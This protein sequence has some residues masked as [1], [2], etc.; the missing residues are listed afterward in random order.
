[1]LPKSVQEEPKTSSQL[2]PTK[3]RPIASSGS[4]ASQ[5]AP[6]I[7]NT[8]QQT[9]RIGGLGLGG[10]GGLGGGLILQSSSSSS[11]DAIA[12]YV[13]GGEGNEGVGV[14]LDDG[15]N[16]RVRPL[17]DYVWDEQ[18]GKPSSSFLA[19][20]E[21][22]K[23]RAAQ[24]T[25]ARKQKQ[26]KDHEET[27]QTQSS[28][29][30][31]AE[32][33]TNVVEVAALSSSS[34]SSSSTV[35]GQAAGAPQLTLTASGEIVVAQESLVQ[36][37]E[38]S[39][40][41]EG[42][43]VADEQSGK[44]SRPT[45]V[46]SATFSRRSRADRWSPEETKLFF[47]ALSMCQTDFSLINML[48]PK[49]N[50]RQ[51]KNKFMREE[52]ERP[53]LVE[54]ALK[55]AQPFDINA[56][57]STIES[58]E[59]ERLQKQQ[60]ARIEREGTSAS[61]SSS[62]N[63]LQ[64]DEGGDDDDAFFDQALGSIK[65]GVG[66][67]DD[68][69]KAKK[70]KEKKEARLLQKAAKKAKEAAALAAGASSFVPSLPTSS[71]P[72]T[73]TITTNTRPENEQSLF[74]T[75]LI[76]NSTK[77]KTQSSSTAIT[78]SL[79]TVQVPEIVSSSSSSSS[80]QQK[81]SILSKSLLP[82]KKTV[83]KKDAKRKRTEEEDEVNHDKG[84]L[85]SKTKQSRKE[86]VQINVDKKVQDNEEEEEDLEALVSAGLEFL[87]QEEEANQQQH[88]EGNDDDKED[89]DE[90]FHKKQKKKKKKN[91]AAVFN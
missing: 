11:S 74:P 79:P 19:N 82:K 72:T 86:V 29:S 14:E 20:E 35:A 22:K 56:F 88:M 32:N 68:A 31:A 46:T 77:I 85:V 17:R 91:R 84:L 3:I 63:L 23:R 36:M 70:A 45:F 4:R 39:Q 89:E 6:I 30:S 90:G 73:T 18:S 54:A 9:S 33:T 7:E 40:P 81:T 12:P 67:Q 65:G 55:L 48:F 60:A 87:E 26:Q 83:M 47:R 71:P 44:H 49:R 21:S 58:K 34:S 24:V 2:K 69:E 78:H 1:M 66:A 42:M 62:N 16:R 50:R 10:L 27:K 28:S 75:S 64:G 61:K 25:A 15:I 80:L 76:L 38:S 52:A 41:G 5:I 43:V 37:L 59:S 53:R 8:D 57:T 51:I 13:F